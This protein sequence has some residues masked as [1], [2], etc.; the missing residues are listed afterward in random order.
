MLIATAAYS[1]DESSPVFDLMYLL[2][3]FMA[4]RQV[5][6]FEENVLRH[7]NMGVMEDID[8]SDVSNR[9]FRDHLQN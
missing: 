6:T 9:F 5:P 1:D 8:H 3:A 2:L 4:S 7:N